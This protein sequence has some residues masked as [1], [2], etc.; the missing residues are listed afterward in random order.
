M[1]AAPDTSASERWCS[2]SL[3]RAML[4]VALAAPA[5]VRESRILAVTVAAR[6]SRVQGRGS[7]WG[8]LMRALLSTAM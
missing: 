3:F 1:N 6:T 8:V 5:T 2:A 7:S 4:S